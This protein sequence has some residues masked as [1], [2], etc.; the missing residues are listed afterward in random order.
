MNFL[1]LIVLTNVL[2]HQYGADDT[3][4]VPNNR[5]VSYLSISRYVTFFVK[6]VTI[7]KSFLERIL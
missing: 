3:K 1:S 4:Y 5:P 7:F 6:Y 2:Y